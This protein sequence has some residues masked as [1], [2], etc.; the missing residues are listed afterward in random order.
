MQYFKA[1]R[2]GFDMKDEFGEEVCREG[3]RGKTVCV[4]K[5]YRILENTKTKDSPGK[6]LGS[7]LTPGECLESVINKSLSATE[8]CSTTIR[9]SVIE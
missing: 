1:K 4:N 2:E 5:K 6:S 7:G 3:R 9:T 8:L